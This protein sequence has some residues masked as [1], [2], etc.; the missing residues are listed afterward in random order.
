MCLIRSL[1]VFCF[2]VGI[3]GTSVGCAD[4]PTNMVELE[5]TGNFLDLNVDLEGRVGVLR[6]I[7]E[8]ASNYQQGLLIGTDTTEADDG[9]IRVFYLTTCDEAEYLFS[10]M[11]ERVAQDAKHSPHQEFHITCRPFDGTIN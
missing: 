10:Q 6:F 4:N 2:T 3:A 8:A 7:N 1:V 9:K 11:I 5:V